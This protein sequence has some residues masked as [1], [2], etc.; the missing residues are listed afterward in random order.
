VKALV[1]LEPTDE[2]KDALDVALEDL[3]H[4]W[5]CGMIASAREQILSL[6]A[7]LSPLWTGHEGDNREAV[8]RFILQW[9]QLLTPSERAE[10][11]KRLGFTFDPV[12]E[13]WSLGVGP[14][15]LGT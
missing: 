15:G 5:C 10:V 11:L 3:C 6:R 7:D 14:G 1:G 13:R 12:D 9:T 4:T 8:D 2:E